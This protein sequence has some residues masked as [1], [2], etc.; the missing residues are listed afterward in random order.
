MLKQYILSSCTTI[1]DEHTAMKLLI[2]ALIVSA[3]ATQ[4]AKRADCVNNGCVKFYTDD[5]CTDKLELGSFR[6]DCTG[7]DGHSRFDCAE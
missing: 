2:L 6:P 3:A 7:E 1:E 5:M 4:L